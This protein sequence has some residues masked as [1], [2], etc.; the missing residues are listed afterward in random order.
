M[1]SIALIGFMGAGKTTIGEVLATYLNIPFLDT[2]KLIEEQYAMSIKD[3]F[4]KYDESGFRDIETNILKNIPESDTVIATGGGIVLKEENR[5][6]LKHMT[7]V[8]LDPDLDVIE[9]RLNKDTQRPLWRQG[10]EKREQLFIERRKYYQAVASIRIHI[11]DQSINKIIQEIIHH[12]H[13]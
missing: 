12:L 1:K 6:I 9:K 11:K 8:W 10:N 7:V 13:L 4:E 3:L 5:Q 2:D